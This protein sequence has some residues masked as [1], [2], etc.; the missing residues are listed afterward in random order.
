MTS[1][2]D[3][4]V[5]FELH[6]PIDS[7]DLEA[8]TM[9]LESKKRSGGGDIAKIEYLNEP[10]SLIKVE[11]EDLA[12]KKR[13][14][15][16]KFLPFKT[17]SIQAFDSN[18][19]GGYKHARYALNPT[20]LILTE[21]GFLN[22][23]TNSEDY[24]TL[25]MYAEHLSPDNDVLHMHESS[26]FVN[27]V[28]VVYAN[29]LDKD[30]LMSRFTKR[31]KL[32]NNAI[33]LVD[34]F[35]TNAMVMVIANGNIVDVKEKIVNEINKLTQP[36]PKYFVENTSAYLM[37]QFEETSEDTFNIRRFIESCRL[38][39]GEL[40]NVEYCGNFEL[41]E[42]IGGKNNE[43]VDVDE[44][45][46]V[47]KSIETELN[48]MFTKK[49]ELDSGEKNKKLQREEK[50]NR[51]YPIV[52]KIKRKTDQIRVDEIEVDVSNLIGSDEDTRIIVIFV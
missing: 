44:S 26:V 41:L 2:S 14:L 35:R 6:P 20:E 23:T 29:A 16:N 42:L 27:T 47:E 10:K 37:F 30:S 32:K 52:E 38:V 3:Q 40:V 24:E 8:I 50:K 46:V 25:K 28:T 36:A 1:N 19:L 34:S 11:Y 4:W 18:I 17:Y 33:K 5:V 21:V 39:L 9:F 22:L 31:P 7:E 45:H 15:D 13:I 49:I 48:T 12:A 43:T 51:E